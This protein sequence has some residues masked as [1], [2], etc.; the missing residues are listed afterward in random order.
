MLKKGILHN[1]SPARQFFKLA[2]RKLCDAHEEVFLYLLFKFF[3]IVDCFSCIKKFVNLTEF[4]KKQREEY[5]KKNFLWIVLWALKPKIYCLLLIFCWWVCK[6]DLDQQTLKWIFLTF[7]PFLWGILSLDQFISRRFLACCK[8]DDARIFFMVDLCLFLLW[9]TIFIIFLAATRFGIFDLI[10]NILFFHMYRMIA[11]SVD[12][13]L[14]IMPPDKYRQLHLE[15]V[16]ITYCRE[17]RQQGREPLV[18]PARKEL[19]QMGLLYWGSLFF[20]PLVFFAACIYPWYCRLK[21][22]YPDFSGIFGLSFF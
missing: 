21:A 19:V 17:E 9:I 8:R 14:I 2:L 4:L 10:S 22:V 5:L 3:S 1:H 20:L 16:I 7:D 12:L 18:T 11:K 13:S 6:K 15:R